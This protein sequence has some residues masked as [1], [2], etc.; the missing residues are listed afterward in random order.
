MD[1]SKIMNLLS[2]EDQAWAAQVAEK[3]KKKMPEVVKRTEGKIPY[4]AVDHVFDDQSGKNICWWTNGFYGGILWE[5]YH[6]TGDELYRKNALELEEKQ[7]ANLMNYVGM[8]HD[9]GFRWLPTAVANYRLTGDEK[10]RNRGL[11]AAENLAGRFNPNGNFIRAWNDAMGVKDPSKE[12]NTGWAIIDCMMN[13]PLLYWA[14]EITK[15]PRY[16]AVALR[17]AETAMKNF[18]RE[19]GSSRHIVEFDPETGAFVRERGGQG[20]GEGT[21]WTRG[22]SWALYGFTLSYIHTRDQKFLDCAMKVA[23][24]FVERIPESFIIPV[25]FDQTEHME[26]Q[27]GTAACISSCG[28]LELAVYAGDKA[29]KYIAAALGMLKCLDE[30]D[31]DYDPAHDNLLCKCTAAYHDKNHNF[32]IIYGDYYFIE[33]IW[34]LIGKDVFIW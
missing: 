16:Q 27:D 12:S 9:S 5:L 25:D 24:R 14:Y 23:D 2:A 22:Q 11:L 10:G 17:H 15:D 1:D 31:C 4:T 18:I 6:V 26:W 8:D 20:I 33:A 19:D 13:L 34:K 21:S 3:I 32:P 29:S 28:L 7:D 30:K